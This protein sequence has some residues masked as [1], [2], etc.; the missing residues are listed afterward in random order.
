MN[1]FDEKK[2]ANDLDKVLTDLED[3]VL[4]TVGKVKTGTDSYNAAMLL[5][6]QG[7]FIKALKDSGY[8]D[9]AQKHINRY[10]EVVT[11]VK[12]EFDKRGMPDASI[13]TVSAD[14]LKSIAK[15]DLEQFR[16]IGTKAMDDLRMK[17]YKHAI[18]GMP[19]SEM[20]AAVRE[21]TT[22][23]DAK[24]SP[25]KN[26]AYTHANTAVL[27]FS[28]EVIREMGE[29]LGAEEWELVGPLD[30]RTRPICRDAFSDKIRTADEWKAAGYWGGS[31]GG[32][33]CRHQL[34]PVFD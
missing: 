22:G 30:A 11:A 8:N 14:K 12:K 5:N 23:I 3:S 25:L 6:S 15:A 33:N 27:N 16:N 13:S 34:Y 21:S 19:F 7:E 31:P 20:V 24:G 1:N 9:L 10:P 26:Y 29:G 18:A 2:F 32:W 4:N 28:G 17:L